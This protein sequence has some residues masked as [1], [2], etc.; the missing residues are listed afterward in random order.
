[1]HYLRHNQRRQEHLASLGLDVHGKSVLEVGA[2]VGDHT[3]FFVDRK[4]SVVALEARYENCLYFQ[5][6][7]ET[8]GYSSPPPVK[9]LHIDVETAARQIHDQFQIV[10]CYGLLYHV[11]DPLSTLRFM[12]QRCGELLLLETCVS[13]GEDQTIHQTQEP[14][15]SPS[16][17]YHGGACRPTRPWIFQRLRELFEHVY[18]PA[19]QPS[20]EEF[21]LDWDAAPPQGFSRAV[22]IASRKPLQNPL[23]LDHLPRQQRPC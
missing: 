7:F 21:P 6:S 23:L 13:F 12:A 5:Q 4:C 10:Y 1:L 19:T 20:H 11:A 22:F 15:Q 18:I 9:V 14:Q 2:G 3:T 16:Q 8:S 17:S